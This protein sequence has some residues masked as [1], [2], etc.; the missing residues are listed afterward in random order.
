MTLGVGPGQIRKRLGVLRARFNAYEPARSGGPK[1]PAL[2][3]SPIMAFTND[4]PENQRAP[5]FWPGA[6]GPTG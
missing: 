2:E 3:V 5:Q 4:Q 6:P 1:H